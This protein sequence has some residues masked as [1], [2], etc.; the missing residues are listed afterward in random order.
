MKKHAV[1]FFSK[2]HS[3]FHQKLNGRLLSFGLFDCKAS[4]THIL[5]VRY[6]LPVADTRLIT[7]LDNCL[8]F[9]TGSAVKQR[10][11]NSD[12][13]ICLDA[14]VLLITEKHDYIP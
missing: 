10:S 7:S 11:P 3:P 13:L 12:D 1:K 4:S 9:M 8:D 5:R 14:D 2:S 6:G